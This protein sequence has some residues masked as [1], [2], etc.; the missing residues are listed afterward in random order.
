MNKK[1]KASGMQLTPDYIKLLKEEGQK[2]WKI[3]SVLNTDKDFNGALL[4]LQADSAAEVKYKAEHVL[5]YDLVKI[6]D[7]F[8]SLKG[9]YDAIPAKAKFVLIYFY[10]ILQGKDLSEAYNLTLIKK[11]SL[12]KQFDKNVIAIR[13]LPF[14]IPIEEMKKELL[15]P[16]V[17]KKINNEQFL[18]ITSFE[19]RVA[20]LIAKADDKLSNKDKELLQK[21]EKKAR[22]PKVWIEEGVYKEIPEDDTLEKVLAE[23]NELVGLEAVKKN[24]KDLT[25]FLKVQKLRE[26]KGLKT[27]NTS[28]H[29]VF[30]G[31]PGTG[32]TTVARLL[33]RIFKHLGYLEK[34]HVVETDRSGLVAGYVGQTAIKTDK[35]IKSALGGVLFIDEAYAL[36]SGGFNDFGGEAIETLLKRM[37]DHRGEFVVVAA[38][39]PDQMEGFIQA[40]PGLQSRFNRY[41]E[42]DHF[43]AD[44]LLKI[45]KLYVGKAD[46]VL[47]E[48]AEEKLVEIIERLYEKRHKGFG[49]ARTMRNLFEKIIERQASRIV[50]ITAITKEVLMEL[51]EEDIPPVIATVK[52]IL[53]FNE[54]ED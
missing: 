7:A 45:F 8:A 6:F 43:P 27:S 16:S 21:I 40:N 18:R 5:L 29:T 52:Q 11:L 38:G 32:K 51:T 50:S 14:F 23:L 4:A 2:A 54:D 31:P 48:D 36:V 34:G 17:L 9:S 30:M 35:I 24:I 28:L 42:F 25:D 15:L 49:N 53:V 10:E 1:P 26:E 20:T 13:E 44:A 3:C 37:E 22:N 47:T 39:Y 12:A 41:F 33:G 19:N 46:F